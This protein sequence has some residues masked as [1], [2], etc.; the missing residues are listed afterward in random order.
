ML[1]DPARLPAEVPVL[2]VRGTVLFPG[3]IAPLALHT[4]QAVEA[5]RA[6]ASGDGLLAVALR[7]TPPR[8]DELHRIATLA[9]VRDL[10]GRG[11]VRCRVVGLARVELVDV[12]PD[13]GHRRARVA[14][15]PDAPDAP[16]P[17]ATPRDRRLRER[18]LADGPDA[19]PELSLPALRSLVKVADRPLLADLVLAALPVAADDKQRALAER[20]V[21]TRLALASALLDRAVA[22]AAARRRPTDEVVRAVRLALWRAWRPRLA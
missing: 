2:A 5:A 8:E 3:A 7:R 22:D 4:D 10:L 14:L 16:A 21:D 12:W 1:L 9:A 17:A 15:A 6:A 18:L 20:R 19:L 13:G 11:K